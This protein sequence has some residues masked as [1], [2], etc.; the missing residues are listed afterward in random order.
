MGRLGTTSLK[1]Y[2]LLIVRIGDPSQIILNLNLDHQ[3]L[4]IMTEANPKTRRPKSNM[5]FVL[6]TTDIAPSIDIQNIREFVTPQDG[7]KGIPADEESTFAIILLHFP[8][9]I[10]HDAAISAFTLRNRETFYIARSVLDVQRS[11]IDKHVQ[12]VILYGAPCTFDLCNEF[13][14]LVPNA[15]SFLEPVGRQFIPVPYVKA[16][17]RQMSI[18]MNRCTD[19]ELPMQISSFAEGPSTPG[20]MNICPRD[21]KIGLF[22]FKGTMLQS[23]AQKVIVNVY[24]NFEEVYAGRRRIEGT[25]LEMTSDAT[26]LATNVITRILTSWKSGTIETPG[27]KRKIHYPKQDQI[28]SFYSDMIKRIIQDFYEKN[29]TPYVADIRNTFLEDVAVQEQKRREAGEQ[30]TPFTC[31]EKTFRKILKRLGYKFDRLQTRDVLLMRPQIVMWRGKYLNILR[32]N[33]ASPNPKK[34]IYLDGINY[35]FI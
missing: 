10:L 8:H 2:H 13:I 28:D 16:N 3:N 7:I 26:S 5:F 4:R 31:S 24:N 1:G 34:I 33:R 11:Y 17:E 9:Q 19:N 12:D 6:G 15:E 27:K 20:K 22:S 21:P 29:R 30:L 32:K 23:S 18:S 14:R 25:P 35:A